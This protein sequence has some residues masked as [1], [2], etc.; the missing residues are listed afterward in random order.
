MTEGDA[1]N[2]FKVQ[3]IP[4]I[5]R[6]SRTTILLK[7][8][9][10]HFEKEYRL[11]SCSFYFEPKMLT[12]DFI[13]MVIKRV[14][15]DMKNINFQENN[16]GFL[17]APLREM[18]NSYIL[19]ICDE[20]GIPDEDF[21]PLEPLS[22]IGEFGS[23]DFILRDNPDCYSSILARRRSRRKSRASRSSKTQVMVKLYFQI[24]GYEGVSATYITKLGTKVKDFLV[25]VLN[26]RNNK[27]K[28]GDVVLSYEL[29]N[30]S[31]E[32]ADENGV[33]CSTIGVDIESNFQGI[34]DVFILR[35][36]GHYSPKDCQMKKAEPQESLL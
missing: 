19:Q 33:S 25:V 31:L 28:E 11:N 8:V 35:G 5:P 21:P 16:K 29:S 22:T 9:K 14:N 3:K 15:E 10:V 2:L 27:R 23:L 30:Y 7:Q 34:G 13:N 6:N 4:R 24:C 17:L 1:D 36:K 32:I 20:N 12:K 18:D 26:D